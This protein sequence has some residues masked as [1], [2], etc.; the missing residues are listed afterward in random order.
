MSDYVPKP[1]IDL[2]AHL[3]RIQGYEGPPAD[4]LAEE[5]VCLLLGDVNGA[6]EDLVLLSS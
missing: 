3:G 2:R 5:T 4:R 6:L 1:L